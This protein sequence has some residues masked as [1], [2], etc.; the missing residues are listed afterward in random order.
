MM[1]YDPKTGGIKAIERYVQ[2][3][4]KLKVR[5]SAATAHVRNDRRSLF[6]V[7]VLPQAGSDTWV[8]R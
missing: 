5:P 2:V 1:E 7:S 6:S 4:L 3:V 8:A